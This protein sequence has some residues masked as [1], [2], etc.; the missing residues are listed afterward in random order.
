[1]GPRR[2]DTTGGDPHACLERWAELRLQLGAHREIIP[3]LS[4]AV[5]ADPLREGLTTLLATAL[6][7]SGQQVDALRVISELRAHLREDLGLDPGGAVAGVEGAILRQE[8]WISGSA[9]AVA[10][11]AAPVGTAPPVAPLPYAKPAPLLRGR[12]VELATV[13][14]SLGF[15]PGSAPPAVLVSGDAGVGKTRLLREAALHAGQAGRRVLWGSCVD[16]QPPMPFLPFLDCLADA[17]DGAVRSDPLLRS[18][19]AARDL[20]VLFPSLGP[21]PEAPAEAERGVARLRLF[22]SITLL[23][24][25]LH[26]QA[27]GLVL[28]LDDLHW[29][30]QASCELLDYLLHRVRDN[31]IGVLAACRPEALLSGHALAGLAPGGCVRASPRTCSSSHWPQ[32]TSSP[33]ATTSSGPSPP[34]Q[35]WTH[36]WR[37]GARATRSS[38]RSWSPLRWAVATCP[39]P[40]AAGR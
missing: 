23:L 30:D 21:A 10:T 14:A 37:R 13:V 11:G 15:A 16:A 35:R 33:S 9:P 28:V 17:V 5:E 32:R 24:R 29:G 19:G 7:R 40:K 27:G 2:G 1:M 22:E 34:R 8:P 12:Q 4:A 39:S 31:G 38:P 18:N 25:S 26:E 3:A 20:A 36:W 6:Y